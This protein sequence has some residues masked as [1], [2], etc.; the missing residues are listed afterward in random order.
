MDKYAILLATYNGEEYIVEMLDSL[1]R[2]TRQDFKC[3]IHDDGSYDNTV[4]LL[5]DWIKGKKNYEI[6]EY[7]Y[8]SDSKEAGSGHVKNGAKNNFMSMLGRVEAEYYMFADQDDVWKDDKV[9]KLTAEIERVTRDRED[10]PTA[11][12]CDMYVV[13]DDL[14]VITD[15]FIKYIGRDIYRNKLPELLIDNPAAGCTMIINKALR[16][17]ALYY[18]NI[19]NIPMHDQW[20]MCVAAA[21]GRISVIDEPLLYYRQHVDNVM[22]A[23]SESK[24]DKVIRNAKDIVTGELLREKKEFHEKEVNLAKELMYVPGIDNRTRK[25]LIDLTRIGEK[26]KLERMEFYRKNG[27]DRKEHSLWM[28]LWV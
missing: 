10:V 6:L 9:S 16:D 2:Q 25:F 17:K 28:R 20:L 5:K 4:P 26:N 8:D 7:E 13:D 12:H 15:S 27:L 11:V 22:G 14:N 21:T 3:Y 24:A 23:K 1:C 18:D 19:D